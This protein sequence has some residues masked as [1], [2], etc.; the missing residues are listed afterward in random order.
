MFDWIINLIKNN[1][2]YFNQPNDGIPHGFVDTDG[3]RQAT[4]THSSNRK[5][6]SFVERRTGITLISFSIR[7]N[8]KNQVKFVFPDREEFDPKQKY[9]IRVCEDFSTSAKY[10]LFDDTIAVHD[11]GNEILYY[12]K[13]TIPWIVAG[14]ENFL[15]VPF[16]MDEDEYFQNMMV[17]DI[18]EYS[19]MQDLKYLGTYTNLG[20]KL[21]YISV[22]KKIN[23]D[24]IKFISSKIEEYS[25]NYAQKINKTA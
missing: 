23:E 22:H 19:F 3:V 17:Y 13:Q 20:T 10:K 24:D 25:K 1:K 14:E 7:K 2:D 18:P 8:H 5:L 15:M 9:P 16:N 6:I 12:E 21:E 4:I 11:Y